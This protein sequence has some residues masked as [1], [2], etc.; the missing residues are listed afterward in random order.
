MKIREPLGS[1]GREVLLANPSR[2]NCPAS[3][4][5]KPVT[6]AGGRP[7]LSRVV[8]KDGDLETPPSGLAAATNWAAGESGELGIDA[9]EHST[10][11]PSPQDH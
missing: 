3:R 1:W 11:H 9:V 7:R 6:F 4:S 2:P 10:V 5:E 8:A